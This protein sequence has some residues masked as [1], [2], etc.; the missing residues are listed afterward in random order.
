MHNTQQEIKKLD[1][2]INQDDWPTIERMGHSIKGSSLGY[3]FKR[4]GLIGRRMQ[5]AAGET[6]DRE[7]LVALLRELIEYTENLQVVYV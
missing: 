4:M 2:A 7:K 1:E 5:A 3:G 6:Q